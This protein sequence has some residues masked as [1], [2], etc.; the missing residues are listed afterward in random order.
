ME[1]NDFIVSKCSH[2]HKIVNFDYS[3]DDIITDKIINIYRSFIFSSNPNNKEELNKVIKLDKVI[4]KYIED[5]SFRKELQNR[6]KYYEIVTTTNIVNTL[7]DNI[8]K[9]YIE[10]KEGTTRR[11]YIAKWI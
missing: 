9:T 4:Y 8:I 2:F 3:K 6:F 1:K 11:I 7:V 5:F 10:Y